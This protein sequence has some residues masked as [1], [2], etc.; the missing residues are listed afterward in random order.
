MDVRVARHDEGVRLVVRAEGVVHGVLDLVGQ[1]LVDVLHL[2]VQLVQ[3][4]GAGIHIELTGGDTAGNI[5]LL[6]MA[7]TLNH[8]VPVEVGKI[9]VDRGGQFAVGIKE[10][11]IILVVDVQF[12]IV[13]D[14]SIIHSHRSINNRT[15]EGLLSR[16]SH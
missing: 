10:G 13:T 14:K 3:V 5:V 1:R 7:D 6:A 12:C 9:R 11:I 4:A 2:V 8:I 15:Y 16:S